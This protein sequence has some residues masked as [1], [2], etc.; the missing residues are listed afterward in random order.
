MGGR[1]VNAAVAL[2]CGVT[3]TQGVIEIAR[4]L[5]RGDLP[6]WLAAT[7]ALAMAA[8]FYRTHEVIE[9]KR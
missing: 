9:R 2:S 6:N 8:A 4:F 7:L 1:L 5:G 3:F